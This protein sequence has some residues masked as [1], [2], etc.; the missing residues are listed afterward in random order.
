MRH[1]NVHNLMCEGGEA[2]RMLREDERLA[3]AAVRDGRLDDDKEVDG[4]VQL[5]QPQ[6]QHVELV[7]EGHHVDDPP[8]RLAS[9]PRHLTPAGGIGHA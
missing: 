2:L 9:R 4:G 5:V 6:L 7:G 3:Q 1:H 8:W